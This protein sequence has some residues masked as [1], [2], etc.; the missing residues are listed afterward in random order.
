[1]IAAVLSLQHYIDYIDW[2]CKITPRVVQQSA[3]MWEVILV[4]SY[5]Y[6]D[7]LSVL[8]W[9]L[10]I[11]YLC[12]FCCDRTVCT[13]DNFVMSVGNKTSSHYLADCARQA[14]GHAR[15]EELS[16]HT[17]SVGHVVMVSSGCDECVEV[18]AGN[19]P[20]TS[21]YPLMTSWGPQ[22]GRKL[23]RRERLIPF[24]MITPDRSIPAIHWRRSTGS[25]ALA[26]VLDSVRRK[27]RPA[28][29]DT[30]GDKRKSSGVVG[31][32]MWQYRPTTCSS[33]T[34][35]WLNTAETTPSNAATLW[36][37]KQF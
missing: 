12:L 3:N 7:F 17:P 28:S 36:S 18:P 32:C 24:R 27:A 6:P 35:C 30:S 37:F 26:D 10:C 22:H 19:T 29:C 16:H 11:C 8:R 23:Y 25:S 31:D 14:S 2:H 20:A 15:H 1:M 4:H 9:Y 21:Y 33:T 34:P 5:S 13:V